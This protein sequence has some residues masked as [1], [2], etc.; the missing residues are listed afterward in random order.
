MTVAVCSHA[1]NEA[2]HA[3]WYSGWRRPARVHRSRQADDDLSKKYRGSYVAQKTD[4]DVDG[5]DLGGRACATCL[6]GK[7]HTEVLGSK[8]YGASHMKIVSRV[9]GGI[10]LSLVVT[11]ADAT[12]I[13]FP[14][15]K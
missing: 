14:T 13:L 10:L 7:F 2:A 5:A 11:S 6:F 3:N 15:P 1:A 4:A 9:L 12:I 8:T